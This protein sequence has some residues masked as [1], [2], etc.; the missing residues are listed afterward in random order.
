MNNMCL[1]RMELRKRRII[2]ESR[3]ASGGECAGKGRV[4]RIGNDNII[5][6]LI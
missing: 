5:S 1:S 6:L 3:I 4:L 2:F